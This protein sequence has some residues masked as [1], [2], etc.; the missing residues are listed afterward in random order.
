M[1]MH[2]ANFA[3]LKKLIYQT[4]QDLMKFD[5]IT[6]PFALLEYQIDYFSPSQIQRTLME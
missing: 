2:Y 4:V 3:E 1:E 5:K 6:S